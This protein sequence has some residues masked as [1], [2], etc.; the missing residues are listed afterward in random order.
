MPPLN[1]VATQTLPANQ[2]R[3]SLAVDSAGNGRVA[4][5]FDGGITVLS[6]DGSSIEH[7]P[8]PDLVTTN[9]CFGGPDLRTAYIT[10]PSTG[11]LVAMTGR[12]PA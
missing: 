1:N 7:I 12:V 11:W 3:D 5:L 4:T 10:L 9:I 2:L 8:M 6:P